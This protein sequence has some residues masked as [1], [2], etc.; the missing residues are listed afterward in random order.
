MHNVLIRTEKA[1]SEQSLNNRRTEASL[2]RTPAIQCTCI[3]SPSFGFYCALLATN[4]EFVSF[5]ASYQ[6]KILAKTFDFLSN[7]PVLLLRFKLYYKSR[8]PLWPLV[9][10]SR[11]LNK[12]NSCEVIY[13]RQSRTITK[14]ILGQYKSVEAAFNNIYM[15]NGPILHKS[16]KASEL[17]HTSEVVQF[18]CF[19]QA[20]SD[21]AAD[22]ARA[23]RLFAIFIRYSHKSDAAAFYEESCPALT[24]F[25]TFFYNVILNSVSILS[26]M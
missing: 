25:I 13:K 23:C 2:R 18:A 1:I 20:A 3:Q 14:I 21:T 17:R 4:N 7:T 16:A 5:T 9:H 10:T 24:S 8:H 15:T 11:Y 6:L 22:S 12:E 19:M 26:V